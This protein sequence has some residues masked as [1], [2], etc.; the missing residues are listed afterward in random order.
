MKYNINNIPS[1]AAFLFFWGHQ[2]S[3]DGSITKSC[4]SQWWMSEFE[5]NG[6]TYSSAEQYM[7]AQK[8]SLFQD[9][10]HLSLI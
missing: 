7:M 10:E 2:P 4:F 6:I 3:K 8:A 1:N 9:E 5:E